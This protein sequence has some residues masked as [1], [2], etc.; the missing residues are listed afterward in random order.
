MLRFNIASDKYN[1]FLQQVR[2]WAKDPNR[3]S[4]GRPVLP[5][6]PPTMQQA[7]YTDIELRAKDD[8]QV[9]RVL[10]VKLRRHDLYIIGYRMEGAN[11]WLEFKWEDPKL[12]LIPNSESLG[13]G[14]N[15]DNLG[16][17]ENLDKVGYSTLKKTIADLAVTRDSN[18][19]KSCLRVLA[20]MIPEAV[21]FQKLSDPFSTAMQNLSD[22]KFDEVWMEELIKSWGNLS[23]MLLREDQYAIYFRLPR[24]KET[25]QPN[26][27]TRTKEIGIVTSADAAKCVALLKGNYPAPKLQFAAFSPVSNAPSTSIRGKGLPLLQVYSVYINNLVGEI[28]L[29]GKVQ[30]NDGLGTF[31]LYNRQRTSYESIQVSEG[32]TLSGP[33]RG[34]S[35]SQY[36]EVNLDLKKRGNSVGLDVDISKGSFSWDLCQL[37][38]NNYYDK[39]LSYVVHGK[40]ASATVY[41]TPF[42]DAV[43]A[44]V[45]VVLVNGDGKDPAEVYGSMVARYS[46]YNDQSKYYQSVLFRKSSKD[47][48]KVKPG[49]SIPLS[50]FVVAVPTLGSLIVDANFCV[51]SGREIAKGIAEFPPQLDGKTVR[52]IKGTYG[53]V[54]VTV[55]WKGRISDD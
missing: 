24:D 14:E 53:L 44:N 8:K 4:H 42:R 43:Q 18:T 48:V 39:Q 7:Q 1:V 21:R 50:R 37:S 9:E 27:L 47:C 45:E 25:N 54:R 33:Y 40:N 10:T 29:Y 17:L 31:H 34:S 30:I 20:V 11:N 19:R 38:N 16:K 32:V 28:E 49:N 22:I 46:N 13:F 36:F 6:P 5:Y 55:S 2:D 35:A 41:Y 12:K 26:I 15:Y 3:F 52:D 23:D 51:S